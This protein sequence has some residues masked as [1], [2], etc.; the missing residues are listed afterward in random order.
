MCVLVLSLLLVVVALLTYTP[1]VLCLLPSCSENS[2]ARV[3]QFSLQCT[4][5]FLV[6]VFDIIVSFC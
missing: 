5:Y 2:L 4:V 1:S 6:F 3:S